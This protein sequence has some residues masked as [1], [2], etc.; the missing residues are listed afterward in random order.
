MKNKVFVVAAAFGMPNMPNG[1]LAVG[2]HVAPA[3]EIASAF[4]VDIFRT[5]RS[6]VAPLE[7]VA[8]MEITEE[9]AR[10]MVTAYEDN[11]KAEEAGRVLP[12]AIVPAEPPAVSDNE[13]EA[14]RGDDRNRGITPHN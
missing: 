3:P 14:R 5:S 10:A 9:M 6:A 12:F 11:A 7:G 13:A 2:T 1:F 4:V 8:V